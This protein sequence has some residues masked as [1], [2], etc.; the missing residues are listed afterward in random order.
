M[1]YPGR[2]KPSTYARA[3]KL[4]QQT[5]F[6]G[7]IFVLLADSGE[8]FLALPIPPPTQPWRNILIILIIF[9][10]H[11]LLDYSHL[12]FNISIILNNL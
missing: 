1:P 5:D 2:Y 10:L 6:A 12:Y 3:L 9:H 7:T 11:T 8:T 4:F